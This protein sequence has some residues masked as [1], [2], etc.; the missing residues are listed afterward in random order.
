MKAV[1]GLS[2]GYEAKSARRV[3]EGGGGARI[4][5]RNGVPLGTAQLSGRSRFAVMF[6]QKRRGYAPNFGRI[7]SSLLV[8]S[9]VMM[10]QQEAALCTGSFEPLFFRSEALDSSS[11][12]PSTPLLAFT[13]ITDCR[14]MPSCCCCPGTLGVL[15]A[16]A[17]ASQ[18]P[19]RHPP[20]TVKPTMLRGCTRNKKQQQGPQNP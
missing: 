18:P 19:P 6:G 17:R 3:E 8:M 20:H 7:W 15:C 16:D 9:R 2:D 14:Y 5:C 4:A 13:S 1:T 10:M 11:V 12:H